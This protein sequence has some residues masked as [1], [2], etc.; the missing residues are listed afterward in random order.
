MG[1]SLSWAEGLLLAAAAIGVGLLVASIPAQAQPAHLAP[2]RTITVSGH[3][4]VAAEPDRARISMGVIS[5]AATAGEALAKNSAAMT[6]II[7]GL[8]TSGIEA[9]DIQT[10]NFAVHPRH[11]HFQDGRP[12]I[13]TGYQVHNDVRVLV[14]DVKRLGAVLDQ[15]VKLGSNQV[16]GI[17]FEVARAD[18]IRDEARKLAIA[19]ALRKARLYAQAAGVTL[20]E[21]VAIEEAGVAPPGRPKVA[22]RAAMMAESAPPIEAGSQLLEA[23][24]IV[25]YALR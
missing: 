16:S 11:Q 19:D 23:R 12:P 14:R 22:G 9:R 6:N 3:G 5:E 13:I 8:K 2:E 25:T 20:G 17:A 24:V 18:E 15:A 1:V 4:S 21:P 10:V 7:A